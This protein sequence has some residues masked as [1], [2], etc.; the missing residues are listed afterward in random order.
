[1]LCG[2]PVSTLLIDFENTVAEMEKVLVKPGRLE[3]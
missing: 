2:E 3:Q 1:M